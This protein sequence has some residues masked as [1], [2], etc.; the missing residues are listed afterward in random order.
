MPNPIKRLLHLIPVQVAP[1]SGQGQSLLDALLTGALIQ[2]LLIGE[3]ADHLLAILLLDH[4]NQGLVGP[5]KLACGFRCSS[6]I[7]IITSWRY[8]P[9]AER[10]DSH[11]AAAPERC[12]WTPRCRHMSR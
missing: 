8:Y 7:W 4:P 2:F 11:D 6:A 9:T 12:A 1:S 3:V 10:G 5:V